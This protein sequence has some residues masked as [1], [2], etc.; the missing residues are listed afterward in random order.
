MLRMMWTIIIFSHLILCHSMSYFFIDADK[1][2]RDIE[3]FSKELENLVKSKFDSFE[4][5]VIVNCSPD[6]SSIF[7]QRV[8]HLLSSNNDGDLFQVINLEMPYPNIDAV[9][10]NEVVVDYETYLD[11]WVD[12]NYRFYKNYIFLDSGCLRGRNFSRL[13]NKLK[14]ENNHVFGCLYLQDDSVFLPNVFVDKF[15]FE[16]DGGLLFF[17][18][19]LDNKNWNY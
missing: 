8:N 7:V 10:V 3:I 9:Y 11:T 1:E 18:E 16:T 5:L 17:W 4:D 14:Y 2:K 6:Y 13:F 15:N 12:N 19:N